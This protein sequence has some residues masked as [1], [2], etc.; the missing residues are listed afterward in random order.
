MRQP[1]LAMKELGVDCRLHER[2]FRFNYCIRPHSLVVWQRPLPPSWDRQ[3]EYLQWL[4]QR[5]C[6]LVTEW[7]D[8]PTLF[9]IKVQTHLEACSMAPLV[10]CHA[11]QGSSA[12]LSTALRCWNPLIICVENGVHP[13]P[14]LK[15][16]KHKSNINR[17][18]IGNQNRSSEHNELVDPLRQWLGNDPSTAAI[19]VGDTTLA[20]KIDKPNQVKYFPLLKYQ[21]YRKV[22]RSCNVM[23]LPLKKGEPERCKTVIKWAEASAESVAVVAGP[24]LYS[25]VE[26]NGEGER[27][28]SI[29]LNPEDVVKKARELTQNKKKLLKQ[30]RTAHEWV[31]QDWGLNDLILERIDLYRSLW[32]RRAKLDELLVNRLIHKAPLLAKG[33]F[34]I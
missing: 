16:N 24:E 5:G 32:K 11:I 15:T 21:D 31:A 34:L 14:K 8:H 18:F 22:L 4:R 27:T 30:T 9:P 6:L 1:F 20:K 23:L 3:I 25:K 17:I 7:D 10:A 13:V 28:C 33:A 19:I 2:P 26:A 29:G 12:A